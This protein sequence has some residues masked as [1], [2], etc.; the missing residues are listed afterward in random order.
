MNARRRAALL[1]STAVLAAATACVAPPP[2]PEPAP[3]P[4]FPVESTAADEALRPAL[5]A[6]LADG[7]A[8]VED[9]AGEPFAEP[10]RVLLLP[11]RA[12]FTASF[13]PEWGMPDTACWMVAAGVADTLHLLSPRAWPRDACE[14]DATDEA[15]VRGIVTHELVHCFHLQHNASRDG[16]GLEP[17][18][19]LV[20]GLAVHVSGQ[21]DAGHRE[22]ARE[23]V[24]AGGGPTRLEDAWSGPA[25]YGVA[26]TLV[27]HVEIRWGRD[28][29]RGLLPATTEAEVLDALGVTEDEL[30]A[31]WRAAL[32]R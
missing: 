6:W 13:P 20:E 22:R 24:A 8:V 31:D 5:D 18:G 30:L 17:L 4:A 23:V 11:D 25:R 19:W 26:G 27:E 10:V 15:H 1:G 28:A 3:P 32:L 14:H 9:W 2:A 21:L 7:R 29:L 16:V 12:A